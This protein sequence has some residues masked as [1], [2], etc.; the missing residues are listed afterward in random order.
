M[1]LYE[2]IRLVSNRYPLCPDRMTPDHRGI[3]SRTHLFS[4]LSDGY[5]EI[6][7][8]LCVSLPFT[9]LVSYYVSSCHYATTPIRQ[10][11]LL[12]CF[13]SLISVF[14]LATTASAGFHFGAFW[15]LIISEFAYFGKRIEAGRRCIRI[16][17]LPL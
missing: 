1:D 11:Y 17:H 12:F 2:F 10:S 16:F 3:L 13:V 4:V 6:C 5:Y 8:M 9:L 7:G 15:R 14:S